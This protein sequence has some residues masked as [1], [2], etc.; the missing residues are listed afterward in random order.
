[1]LTDMKDIILD[2]LDLS[3]PMIVISIVI[4]VSLRIVDILIKKEKIVFY[5]EILKLFFV[6]YI[7]CLFQVVTYKDV[8]Y[9]GM[10]FIPFK[11]MFR[12]DV[13]SYLFYK[14]IL[15]NMLLFAPF[16]F[17]VG[18]IFNANKTYIIFILSIIASCSIEITQLSIGR[19]F[20]V[21]D[22]ILNVLG[23][24]LGYFIYKMLFKF[25][26]KI[27]EKLKQNWI[28]NIIIIIIIVLIVRFIL[29]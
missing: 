19:V 9:G 29:L 6:I 7:L 12:Y 4:I 10:N 24:L 2:M 13:G 28:I 23:S 18:Y 1:M 15:G 25:N 11:E 21:D 5:K 26:S 3:W 22:I 27:P 17:F 20:D 16:G 8:N 14:N